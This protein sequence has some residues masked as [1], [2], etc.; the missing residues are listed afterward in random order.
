[1]S[2]SESTRTVD[3]PALLDIGS[4]LLGDDDAEGALQVFN[5]I[6]AA[7]PRNVDA[8]VGKGLALIE[9]GRYDQATR[10][11]Q[12]A[13]ELEPD[14][15][16]TWSALGTA[17]LAA[18]DGEVALK[19]YAR[20][21]NTQTDPAE[22]YLN[23]ARAAYFAL[24]LERAR[25]YVDLAL[26]ENPG[27][28]MARGWE[29][30]LCGLP[31]HAAFLVDVGRAHARRG[32]MEQALQLFLDSLKEEDSADAHLYAGRALFVLGRAAE[33]AE[34]LASAHRMNAQDP[35]VVT[36]LASALALAGDTE[37]ARKLFDEAL[38]AKPQDEGALLGKAQLLGDAGDGAAVRP[39]LDK[40]IALAPDNPSVWFLQARM[41]AHEGRRL[42]ARLAAERGIVRD[43][44]SASVWLQAAEVM[45]LIGQD[46]LSHLC[47]AR[48]RFV[49]TG[50][51]PPEAVERPLALQEMASEIAELDG[52]ELP[53]ERMIES[54]RNRITVCA[55]LGQVERAHEYLELLLKRYP[56][57]E[58]EEL[59]RHQGS[60]LRK[61]GDAPGARKAF[62]RALELDPTSERARLGLQRLEAFGA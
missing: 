35:G 26:A 59:R 29:S 18:G 10:F 22:N 43:V 61:T 20:L 14:R 51:P 21:Q 25:D 58:T 45:K 40:L 3:I 7:T 27:L 44:R 55:N 52:M 32:R 28:E 49:E 5:S 39:L 6:L 1:M 13:S 53:D 54:L 11:L 12:R 30:A 4:W 34:H 2:T 41:L 36:E 15:E 24:D 19:A 17:A 42:N 46:G 38:S 33:A 31:N 56:Q 57:A 62:E 9:L 48:A 37:Q 60:L 50:K 8:H 23:L 16:S 47:S